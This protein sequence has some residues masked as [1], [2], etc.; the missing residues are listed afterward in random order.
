MVSTE[1]TMK[2]KEYEKELR[3]L[4]VELC[5]L[6]DWVRRSGSRVVVDVPSYEPF[7]ALPSYL[8]AELLPLR[9]RLEDGWLVDPA[10]VKRLL[11]RGTGPGHVFLANLHN[12]TGTCLDRERMQAIALEAV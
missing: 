9:R 2:R 7:R 1:A 10:D 11:S 4:Q 6:Q 3:K 5:A 8:G 12:P